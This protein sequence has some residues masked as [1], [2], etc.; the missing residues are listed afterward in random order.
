MNDILYIPEDLEADDATVW[1]LNQ[2]REAAGRIERQLE[3]S[4]EDS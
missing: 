4:G 2:I 1:Q 3:N